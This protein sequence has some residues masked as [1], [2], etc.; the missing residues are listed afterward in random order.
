MPRRPKPKDGLTAGERVAL[1]EAVQLER[2]RRMTD[3][4]E[5]EETVETVTDAV[6][7]SVVE[8]APVETASTA[9]KPK[10]ELPKPQV[11]VVKVDLAIPVG[12][13]KPMHGMCNGPVSY[14]ADISG[15]F[16][17]IGV[18]F[19]RFD[20]TDTAVSAHAV[21][22][23]RIFKDPDADPSDPESYDFETTDRYVEAAMLSGAQII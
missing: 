21:D 6:V 8:K 16:K 1:Y 5:R 12:E 14:G 18:P 9:Q 4:S 17:E 10:K 7:T 3:V 11:A 23:S 13:I 22:V 19:V 2:R 20:A 15:L